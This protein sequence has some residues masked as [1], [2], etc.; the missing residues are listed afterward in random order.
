MADIRFNSTLAFN[1]NGND[2]LN[3]LI[4]DIFDAD[5]SSFEINNDV[6]SKL[7]FKETRALTPDQKFRQSIGAYELDKID[8]DQDFPVMQTG[9]AKE[10]GFVIDQYANQIPITKLFKKW[11]E[12][13][14]TLTGADTSVQKEWVDLANNIRALRYGKVKVVNMVC[15]E[16]FT[17]GFSIS[18]QSGPGSATAYGQ[19]L[20]SSAHPYGQ[21]ANAGTFQNVLGGTGLGTLN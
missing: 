17:K 16:L 11:I 13:A 21:G 19:S 5:K 14:Q 18:T 2:I 7:G 8:E 10:K 6:V 3:P 4:S 15:T 20:F 12:A 1:G 9:F